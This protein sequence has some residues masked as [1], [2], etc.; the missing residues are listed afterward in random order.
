MVAGIFAAS[1]LVVFGLFWPN[2]GEA[3]VMINF[4]DRNWDRGLRYDD[5]DYRDNRQVVVDKSSG[6]RMLRVNYSTSTYYGT[7]FNKE[8]FSGDPTQACLSYEVFFPRDF[9]FANGG[10]LPGLYGGAGVPN[11]D[12]RCSGGRR[13]NCFSTR[14]MWRKGGD[15]EAYVYMSNSA[16]SQSKD[17]LCAATRRGSGVQNLCVDKGW[18][19][20]RGFIT[21][22]RGA[23]NQIRQRVRMNTIDQRNGELEV[24]VVTNRN[25]STIIGRNLVW[26]TRQEPNALIR[27][28]FFSTFYGG[29]QGKPLYKPSKD[30]FAIF[31][32][33]NIRLC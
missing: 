13:N 11:N 7:Q 12:Q 8:V 16:G 21:F 6:A 29:E 25:S 3:N 19:Y 17:V 23:W 2:F 22:Q 32:N 4:G 1:F 33:I 10:K 14:M 18:S 9:D 5:K 28:L 15:A 27:G 31:R 24:T 30:G 26:R 20:Q